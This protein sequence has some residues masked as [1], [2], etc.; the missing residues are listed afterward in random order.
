[1]NRHATKEATDW[2]A[3][4]LKNQYRSTQKSVYRQEQAVHLSVAEMMRNHQVATRK[5]LRK[6]KKMM[7]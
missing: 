7:Q 6:P 2:Q 5:Y 3:N 4:K 1:V